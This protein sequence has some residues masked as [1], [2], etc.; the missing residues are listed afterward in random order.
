MQLLPSE[1]K[2]HIVTELSSLNSLAAL[3]RTHTAFQREAERALYHTVSIFLGEDDALRCLETLL[4]NSEKAAL[5]RSL[6]MM[7]CTRNNPDQNRRAMTL[8]VKVLINMHSLSEFRLIMPD[9]SETRFENRNESIKNLNRILWLVYE[10]LT[11]LKLMALLEI[12]RRPFSIKN[13]L[14]RRCS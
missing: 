11:F 1:L 14:L 2:H 8:L 13:S 5:V 6:M 9:I 4:A 3:A 7:E 12:Q 10:V